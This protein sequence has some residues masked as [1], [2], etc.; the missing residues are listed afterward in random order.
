MMARCEI[1][2]PRCESGAW[3][4]E[5]RCVPVQYNEGSEGR[6]RRTKAHRG[7]GSVIVAEV[8]GNNAG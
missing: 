3:S 6:A 7:S 8:F 2:E 5:D 4:R 1:A